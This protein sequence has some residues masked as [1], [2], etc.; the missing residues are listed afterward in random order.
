M[1]RFLTKTRMNDS[2][3]SRNVSTAIDISE[4]AINDPEQFDEAHAPPTEADG[5][6]G[7]K[8][9]TFLN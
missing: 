8:H 1:K 4:V 6:E 9:K 2:K 7:I 5:F 3:T